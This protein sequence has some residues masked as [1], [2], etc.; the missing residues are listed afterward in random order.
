ML[1]WAPSAPALGSLR[2]A[3]CAAFILILISTMPSF[4]FMYRVA[5]APFQWRTACII[6]Q[7]GSAKQVLS[8]QWCLVPL[9]SCCVGNHAPPATGESH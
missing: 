6:S 7:V 5:P 4:F 2:T 3:D 8:M 1:S 9:S